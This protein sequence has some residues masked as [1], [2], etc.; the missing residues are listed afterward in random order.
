MIYTLSFFIRKAMK[1][2]NSYPYKK[3]IKFRVKTSV[4]SIIGCGDAILVG[5]LAKYKQVKR[6]KKCLELSN[7][8]GFYRAKTRRFLIQN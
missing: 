8:C 3:H 2:Y 6:L 4:V 5:L 7:Q 1:D